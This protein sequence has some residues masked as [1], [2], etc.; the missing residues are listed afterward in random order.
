MTNK[1]KEILNSLIKD[2][3]NLVQ[4]KTTVDVARFLDYVIL[5]RRVLNH[6]DEFMETLY[7]IRYY[8]RNVAKEVI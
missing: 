8:F 1:E 4:T 6:T 3:E 5:I 2:I 7:F